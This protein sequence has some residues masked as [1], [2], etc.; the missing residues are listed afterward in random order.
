M[1]QILSKDNSNGQISNRFFRNIREKMI[2][3][4]LF[5]AALSSVGTT[6]G[7]LYILVTESWL[8]IR[9]NLETV[10]LVTCV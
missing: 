10:H 2:E 6:F 9:I 3:F 4:A 8:F 7:I 5:L 1:T